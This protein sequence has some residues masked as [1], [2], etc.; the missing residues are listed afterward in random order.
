VHVVPAR[1][2]DAWGF[3]RE[4]ERRGLLNGES[5]DVTADHDGRR[6]GPPARNPA[7][8]SG[9]GDTPDLGGAEPGECR[10]EQRRRR[11]FLP[12]ELRPA[13]QLAT[14]RDDLCRVVLAEAEQ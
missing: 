10:L 2:H 5:V 14:Q 4:L 9:A 7:H 6:S 1:V 13:V 12:G 8:H 3:R 11:L